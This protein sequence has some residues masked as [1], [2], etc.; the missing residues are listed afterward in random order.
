MLFS[1]TV[2]IGPYI[3]VL[4]EAHRVSHEV[5][6]CADTTCAG[7]PSGK[8]SS[9]LKFCGYCGSRNE[10]VLVQSHDVQVP[11]IIGVFDLINPKGCGVIANGQCRFRLVPDL[12]WDTFGRAVTL[13]MSGQMGEGGLDLSRANPQAEMQWLE[14][15]FASE[16]ERLREC[17]VLVTVHWGAFFS[18]GW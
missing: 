4:H 1:N 6:G 10:K 8:M 18:E 15:M 7:H 3:E 2:Y 13:D 9:G 11:E 12:D 5:M 14:K 16:I 17:S